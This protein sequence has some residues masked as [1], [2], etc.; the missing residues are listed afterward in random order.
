MH[1]ERPQQPDCLSNSDCVYRLETSGWVREGGTVP[2]LRR[3]RQLL[4]RGRSTKDED[5]RQMLAVLMDFAWL[6]YTQNSQT[7]AAPRRDKHG[8]WKRS[9]GRLRLMWGSATS[10]TNG[11]HNFIIDFFS[12][13]NEFWSNI[14]LPCMCNAV[15][16][17]YIRDSYNVISSLI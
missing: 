13:R 17:E 9:A 5:R 7:T 12:A 14:K 16:K 6:P 11:Q 8:Q 10:D 2:R 1:T 3:W 4:G 15:T